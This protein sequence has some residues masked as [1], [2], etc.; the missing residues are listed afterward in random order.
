[1]KIINVKHYHGGAKPSAGWGLFALLVALGLI[2]KF[3]WFI[4]GLLYLW[5]LIWHTRKAIGWA[6]IVG[7]LMFATWLPKT[8]LALGMTF[9]VALPL[10]VWLFS[11]GAPRV[12]NVTNAPAR[13]AENKAD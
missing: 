1:M 8:P 2:S 3:F 7:V 10:L 6:L 5:F 9:A 4:A 12:K 13:L 11:P